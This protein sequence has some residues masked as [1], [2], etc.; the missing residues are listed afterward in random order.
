MCLTGAGPRCCNKVY[1]APVSDPFTT[2]MNHI[3]TVDKLALVSKIILDQRV[4]ELRSENE[5]LKL[6]LFW[7]DHNKSSLKEAMANGNNYCPSAPK[8]TCL[9]CVVSGRIE[10]EVESE[11]AGDCRFKPWFEQKLNDCGM[12]VGHDASLRIDNSLIDA[13]NG[14]I[15]CDCHFVNFARCDWFFFSYGKK[16]WAAKTTLSSSR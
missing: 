4:L 10:E 13:V 7:K 11:D 5:E 6:K 8:C 16:L 15:D 14:V 3:R 9:S 1:I 12:T 2:G